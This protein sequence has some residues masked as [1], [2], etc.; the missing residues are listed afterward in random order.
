MTK[1]KLILTIIESEVAKK[2]SNLNDFQIFN[3]NEI[4]NKELKKLIQAI[5]SFLRSIILNT[6]NYGAYIF[7]QNKE[8]MQYF[9][10][11]IYD[12]FNLLIKVHPVFVLLGSN[13]LK[14]FYFLLIRRID[15]TNIFLKD[16]QRLL[17]QSNNNINNNKNLK[18]V[19]NY[20]YK[21]FNIDIRII[22][23]T[24][25]ESF[26]HFLIY[27]KRFYYS[28]VN[29]SLLGYFGFINEIIFPENRNNIQEEE[30]EEEDLFFFAS[31]LY[32]IFNNNFNKEKNDFKNSNSNKKKIKC[33]CNINKIIFKFLLQFGCCLD[34][35]KINFYS[36]IDEQAKEKLK[37]QNNLLEKLQEDS[38]FTD[39][40]KIE[41]FYRSSLKIKPSN[42]QS[43]INAVVLY[44]KSFKSRKDYEKANILELLVAFYKTFKSEL[45]K[46][47]LFYYEEK[48]LAVKVE[49]A[50][51]QL[52]NHNKLFAKIN[53]FFEVE[54]NFNS[55]NFP[56]R[57]EKKLESLEK[58]A[59][60]LK[61]FLN[62]QERK[63]K[64]PLLEE[65]EK[66]K[67]KDFLQTIIAK[68]LSQ[69]DSD[70]S[71]NLCFEDIVKY[72]VC[73]LYQIILKKIKEDKK[74]VFNIQ[75]FKSAKIKNFLDLLDYENYDLWNF[76]SITNFVPESSNEEYISFKGAVS[77]LKISSLFSHEIKR[78]KLVDLGYD[79][80][81]PKFK[82]CINMKDPEIAELF[83][84]IKM[85]QEFTKSS[86]EEE[87]IHLLK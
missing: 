19:A 7:W 78:Q 73:N 44:L 18:N 67:D 27:A 37:L 51:L 42:F 57:Y 39:L 64:M 76:D 23:V 32:E 80:T 15:A 63:Q 4:L 22:K 1:T 68:I 14:K 74:K 24:Y 2:N 28:Y 54:E 17:T 60:Q 87:M 30:D 6:I 8:Y 66:L 11:N 71:F 49:K 9:F 58:N 65:Y 46:K 21:K 61:T 31:T 29:V 12:L 52:E 56:I 70:F 10:S 85:K 5:I 62:I 84:N 40:S 38:S 25:L 43:Q 13:F 69:Q 33:E 82:K 16:T 83:N 77:F 45:S 79:L 55:E 3:Q 26:L 47:E 86:S 35:E 59:F 20:N 50:L 36:C 34:I 41:S 81:E 75:N 72:F 48:S 53:K